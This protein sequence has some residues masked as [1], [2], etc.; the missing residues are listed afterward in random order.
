MVAQVA[1]R[2]T[3]LIWSFECERLDD[4]LPAILAAE[5]YDALRIVYEPGSMP[6]LLRFLSLIEQRTMPNQRKSLMIDISTRIRA[7]ISNLKQPLELE[8]GKHIT[9]S[10]SD[11]GG[12]IEIKT[13]EWKTLFAVDKTVYIGYGNAALKP[14]KI[15]ANKIEAEVVQ[16]GIAYPDMDLHIPATQA[17]SGIKEMPRADLD[18]LLKHEIDFLVIPASESPQEIVEFR[19]ELEKK[20]KTPPWM[21]LK[22]STEQ[23]CQHLEVLLPVVDGVMISRLEMALSMDPALIPIRTKELLQTCADQSKIAFTASEML[24]SMR[25]NATPTRAEVSDIANAVIDGTDAVVLSEEVA[26]GPH[27]RRAL[28]LMGQ[29][30]ADIEA[31]HNAA[32]NWVRLSPKIENEMD[33]IAFSAY[34][35]AERI[36]TKAIVCITVGGNTAVRLA[37]FRPPIPIIA[38]TFDPVI[39]RRL[40]LVRG[41]TGLALDSDPNIDQVLPMVNDRLVRGSFLKAGDKIIFVSITLSSLSRESSN[42]LTVQTLT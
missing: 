3:K 28:V 31:Q 24:G 39:L 14:R 29:I 33:A 8:F 25:H 9:I 13:E 38:V 7:S 6:K 30:V 19:A 40:Q 27:F 32:P 15:S 34:K 11:G 2:R 22:V 18:E 5:D 42:L 37:T 17:P 41:V 4:S 26:F 16:G 35:T 23:I 12:D 20:C 36:Q 10:P 1:G 21:I